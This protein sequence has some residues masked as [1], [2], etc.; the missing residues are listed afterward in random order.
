MSGFVD[1]YMPEEVPGYPCI[2]TPRTKTSIQVTSGGREQRNQ[3]WEHPL[4]R[5]TLPEAPGR[6]WSVI[7]ALKKHWLAVGRG[8]LKS[9][10]WRDP[11]DFA[12]RDLLV[13][14][15]VTDPAVE[16]DDQSIGTGDGIATSFQLVKR[17][18]VGGE[19]YTRTIT[20]PVL[21]SVIVAIGG[22][23]VDPA[24]YT[25]TRPGGVVTFNTAPAADAAITA[26]F[27][28]DV[29]V[30]FEDD[31]VFDGILRT[32]QVGGFADLSLIEVRPC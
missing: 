9:W 22:V 27:L 17:Y 3:E 4:Y 21:D 15:P 8:P 26:G 16:G 19:T 12:S 30:R 32:Y 23:T 31:D 24:D 14:N 11:L 6:D 18:I 1:Q 20:L 28:F 29:P 5:F 25:V 7:E 13:P 2:S 10:P